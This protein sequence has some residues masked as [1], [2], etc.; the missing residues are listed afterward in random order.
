MSWDPT[1]YKD[2]LDDDWNDIN[3]RI[4]DKFLELAEEDNDIEI[5][6]SEICR[7]LGNPTAYKS[8]IEWI[9]EH[10]T[11]SEKEIISYIMDKH[12]LTPMG[13][14]R[15]K[16]KLAN[17]TEN[18]NERYIKSLSGLSK[19]QK[20]AVQ[21]LEDIGLELISSPRQLANGTLYFE[22]TKMEGTFYSITATGYARRHDTTQMGGGMRGMYQPP[23]RKYQLNK[24]DFSEDRE[25]SRKLK[26][27]DYAGLAEDIV[28]AVKVY[29]TRSWNKQYVKES[30]KE[31]ITRAKTVN[32]GMY[33]SENW[34]L[35]E[36]DVVVFDLKDMGA[37]W[38]Y[39]DLD[40]YKIA[41]SHNGQK[42]VIVSQATASEVGDRDYEYYD[43]EFE[44]GMGLDAVSGYH[45]DD[46]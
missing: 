35:Q 12:Y 29:R 25:V 21:I 22:D 42:A 28:N 24:Q 46:F 37:D 33:D 39:E 34:T 45:L 27:G 31:N 40:T 36:G 2:M 11:V 7:I 4:T 44:D 30:K 43:I 5:I 10:H 26:P 17:M 23:E 20:K 18:V 16:Q 14:K 1:D 13:R 3:D 38:K 32:E 41:K 15:I 19:N 6:A 8:I 9:E